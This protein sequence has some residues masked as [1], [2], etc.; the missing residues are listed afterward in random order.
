MM[1]GDWPSSLSDI[2]LRPEEMTDGRYLDRV[3]VGKN[4]KIMA[5]LS[6]T[7]G[8]D[9]KLSLAPRSIMG[10]MQTRWEC[11][12]NL[13]TKGMIGMSNMNCREDKKLRYN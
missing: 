1:N 8:K 10:G 7:F 11:T 9:K 2:R 3:R 6:D 4:G 12:T 5:Y 13:N